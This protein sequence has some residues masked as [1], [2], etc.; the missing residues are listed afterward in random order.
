MIPV[1]KAAI[2]CVVEILLE[3]NEERAVER[4][5]SLEAS[6]RRAMI[7]PSTF[8]SSPADRS[9][10]TAANGRSLVFSDTTQRDTQESLEQPAYLPLSA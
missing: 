10:R 4:Y 6:A 5:M 8:R 3:Q 1:H 9:G 7:L 2:T